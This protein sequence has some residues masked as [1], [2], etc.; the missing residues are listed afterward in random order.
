MVSAGEPDGWVFKD[1]SC[2]NWTVEP[3]CLEFSSS[4]LG[5]VTVAA[6]KNEVLE[7]QGPTLC[8]FLDGSIFTWTTGVLKQ[9]VELGPLGELSGTFF[10]FFLTF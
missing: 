3:G 10:F 4:E 8:V 9:P 1:S 2:S 6:A 7:E 5:V